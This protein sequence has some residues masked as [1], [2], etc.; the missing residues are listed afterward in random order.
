MR[1]TVDKALIN[2][3]SKCSIA[4]EVGF[5]TCVQV[6]LRRRLANSFEVRKF[7]ICE[8]AGNIGHTAAGA[9][10]G[11]GL[12]SRAFLNCVL[13]AGF[14]HGKHGKPGRRYSVRVLTRSFVMKIGSRGAQ[15]GLR[16]GVFI[17]EDLGTYE[18]TW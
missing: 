3:E 12:L 17:D 10:V 2:G 15:L 9:K 13:L 18:D 8:R 14:G 5:G 16:S 7:P 11:V 1:R 6:T 4:T